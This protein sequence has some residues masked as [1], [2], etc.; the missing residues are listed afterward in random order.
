MTP[1][2]LTDWTDEE[3]LSTAEEN[4]G[5]GSDADLPEDVRF[6]VGVIRVIRKRLATTAVHEGAEPAVFFYSPAIP[7][8]VASEVTTV[9]ML[10]NGQN[11]LDGKL[12]FVGVVAASG[13]SYALESWDDESVFSLAS[14]LGLGSVPAVVLDPRLGTP[15]VR[16]YPAGLEEPDERRLCRIEASS[17]TIADVIAAVAAVHQQSLITPSRQPGNAK[18]WKV[19]SKHWPRDDA[20][21][22]IQGLLHAGLAGAFPSCMIR[23]EESQ[24]TGRIDLEIE[25]P[26]PGAD[27]GFVRL[28]LLELKVLRSFGSTGK[29]VTAARTKQWVEEGVVQAHAYRVDRGTRESALCCFDMRKTHS[30]ESCFDHVKHLAASNRVV[31]DVRHIFASSNALRE[32]IREALG[33]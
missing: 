31:L 19:Q 14:D 25:E 32:H 12:W 20:E 24:A 21:K 28:A 23:P 10:D 16:F 33:S 3:L 8:D 22:R 1:P 6:L 5:A 17:A 26:L 27:G 11:A 15:E 7:P 4:I 13:R 9:P 29:S 18:L 30:G 2:D